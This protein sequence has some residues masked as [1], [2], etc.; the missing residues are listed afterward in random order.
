MCNCGVWCVGL[1]TACGA[2]VGVSYGTLLEH[3]RYD[4]A[5]ARAS[6]R[7][8]IGLKK[9]PSYERQWLT[10]ARDNAQE[11]EYQADD[12]GDDVIAR[13][14]V[15][16]Q[17]SSRKRDPFRLHQSRYFVPGAV[18]SRVLMNLSRTVKRL[19][20]QRNDGGP[21]TG[22]DS[23]AVVEGAPDAVA[24]NLRLAQLLQ[25][26]PVSLTYRGFG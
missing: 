9:I 20:R 21:S 7:A 12:D 11:S 13:V 16:G 8:M 26:C 24:Q 4:D 6:L 25:V 17:L 22:T 2:L 14:Q 10:S 23:R 3:P 5:S 18:P 19:Q 15:V 1:T